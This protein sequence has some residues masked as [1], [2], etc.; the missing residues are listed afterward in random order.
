MNHNVTQDVR[1]PLARIG[2]SASPLSS[3]SATAQAR[4]TSLAEHP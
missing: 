3:P 2:R 4:L 1:G